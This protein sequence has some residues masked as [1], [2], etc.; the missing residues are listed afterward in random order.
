MVFINESDIVSFSLVVPGPGDGFTARILSSGY[1]D[2]IGVCCC[3]VDFLPTWQI[4]AASSPRGPCDQQNLFVLEGRQCHRVT[5][6]VCHG[7]VRCQMLLHEPVS[8]NG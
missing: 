8:G 6:T 7:E 5:F 4:K 3:F 2:K 1:D